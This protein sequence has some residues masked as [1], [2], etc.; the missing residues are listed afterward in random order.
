MVAPTGMKTL[1]VTVTFERSVLVS[2]TVTPPAGAACDRVTANAADCPNTSAVLAGTPIARVPT[3]TVAVALAIPAALAVM[4]AE[5]AATPVTG[6]GTLVAPTAKFTL[7]GTVTL[8]GSL[9]PRLTVKPPAGAGPDRFSV[10]FPVAPTVIDK[11]DPVKLIV[12]GAC[13]VTL[14]VALGRPDALAVMV[15]E[16]TAT[17]VTGTG[18]L[19][20]PAAKFTL[21]GTVALLVSLEPRLTVNPPAGAGVDRFSVRFWVLPALSVRLPGVKLS[22]VGT[23]TSCVADAN[24]V[25]VAVMFAVP[26]LM[27]VTCGCA[28]GVV[29]PPAM[30]A[31][32][33]TI[34]FERSLLVRFTVTP[35]GGAFDDRLMGNATDWPGNTF[36]PTGR[37]ICPKDRTFTVAVVG[38][39]PGALA[40][41]VTKPCATPVTGTATLLVPATKLTVAGTVALLGSLELRLII[42]PPAGASPPVRVSVRFPVL[43]ARI[44]KLGGEKMIPPPTCTTWLSPMKP[45]A[46]ALMVAD[47]KLMPFTC[48]CVAGSDD[49]NGIKTLEGVMVTFEG[50]LLVSVMVTPPTG[51]PVTKCTGNG[52]DWFGP[53][54][55]PIGRT[56]CPNP[57]TVT[58]AKPLL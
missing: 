20:A 37:I 33:V 18:T 25:A 27:P 43:P 32:A 28:A 13:T 36:T 46:D 57:P 45:G 10:R 42:K 12:S 29:A 53:T 14:A 7:A 5:P 56:I 40:V 52:T 55:T 47:P 2:V 23:V 1:G 51:A 11:G 22:G 9:E 3:F 6:T 16:P 41:I 34:T 31:L 17:P 49:L 50:S 19:V 4:V 30:K 54:V 21:A 38:V 39:K 15:A 8:P 48:G 24:P 26:M 44:P 35:P 58:F